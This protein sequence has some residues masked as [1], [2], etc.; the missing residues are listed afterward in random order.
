M[1]PVIDQFHDAA[2]G[3]LYR[4][5][6]SMPG[7]E[8]FVKTASVDSGEAATLPASAFAWPF[9]RRFPIHTPEHA[10]LSYA[11]SKVA[12]ELPL[13][14]HASIE[15]ALTVYSI[16]TSTFDTVK[17]AAAAD[18]AYLLPELK[19]FSVKTAAETKRAQFDLLEN[20]QKLDL[21]HS[22]LRLGQ[23]VVPHLSQQ[24]QVSLH[25]CLDPPERPTL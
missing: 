15:E 11:Y 20:I 1:T 6:Q 21:Q 19:L 3:V 25:G 9:E 12:G 13:F 5:V 14:V 10:A 2:F 4:Q 8:A 24:L 16:P 22:A 18:D 17:T 23:L 7:L